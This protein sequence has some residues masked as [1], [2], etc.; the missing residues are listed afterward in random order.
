[1]RELAVITGAGSGIGK[2]MARRLATE[3][4]S[5]IAIGRR[6]APLEALAHEWD[7]Q[8]HAARLSQ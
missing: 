2:A 1:M 6:S 3:G 4:L 8:E 7:V 5:V